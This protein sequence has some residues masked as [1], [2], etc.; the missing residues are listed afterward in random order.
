MFSTEMSELINEKT[1]DMSVEKGAFG[2][3]APPDLTPEAKHFAQSLVQSYEAKILGLKQA[4]T[5]AERDY[6]KLRLEFDATEAQVS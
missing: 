3:I 4:L 6:E 5:V 2:T 1:W